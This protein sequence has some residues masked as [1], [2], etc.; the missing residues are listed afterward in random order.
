MRIPEQTDKNI[1]KFCDGG[2]TWYGLNKHHHDL[3]KTGSIIGSTV[4]DSNKSWEDEN[5]KFTADLEVNGYQGTWYC[6]KCEGTGINKKF[7][8]E[9]N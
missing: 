3:N 9:E 4:Y 6:K 2:G 7:W 5:I 1:C 8:L